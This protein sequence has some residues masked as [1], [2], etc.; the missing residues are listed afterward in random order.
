M[1]E[2]VEVLEVSEEVKT[3]NNSNENLPKKRMP[4]VVFS[5][6]MGVIFVVTFILIHFTFSN[7]LYDNIE[8]YPFGKGIIG[9]AIL[10]VL[11]FLVMLLWKN[12]YVFTQ[13]KE[14]FSK[15][16]VFGTFYLT[17]GC[18]IMFFTSFTGDINVR[19][20]INL[21]IF[22]FLIGVYEEFL[23]RGWLLNE[24]LER[25]GKDNK[26][27][28]LCICISGIIFGLLHSINV[29]SGEI[30]SVD[31]IVQVISAAASGIGFGTIYYKT[32]N[33]WSVIFLHAFWDF[34]LML[35]ETS[36]VSSVM[37]VS[38]GSAIYSLVFGI[39]LAV[40]E[41]GIV[42]PFRKDL[43]NSDPKK[44]KVIG[45]GIGLGLLYFVSIITYAI[46]DVSHGG[47]EYEFDKIDFNSTKITTD[48]IQTYRI[49]S[50]LNDLGEKYNY[51]LF[52]NEVN[53]SLLFKNDNTN[54]TVVLENSYIDDYILAEHDDK[55]IIG[56][57]MTDDASNHIFKYKTIDKSDLSNSKDFLD[58]V[59]EKMKSYAI[60]DV[61]ELV[62]IEDG[63]NG[64]FYV[65]VKTDDFGYFVL[66][67]DNKMSVYTGLHN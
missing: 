13:K 14:K 22:C 20:I 60:S 47:K 35:S 25:Y 45:I 5:I 42:L 2:N 43:V 37:M 7:F 63:D 39:L 55:Y 51:S 26:S 31:V 4:F 15:G 11:V 19:S 34:S 59:H 28:F 17:F 64:D 62:T 1:N 18:I 12:S 23:C 6:L 33:I 41:L 65:A 54:D 9:E 57:V 50:S 61:G 48:N 49:D 56:Y 36:T 32:K 3:T 58:D 21:A 46:F 30:S 24:F 52:Y 66:T 67:D 10:A 40:I 27:I 29:L 16:L 53:K 44:G 8:N 38:K